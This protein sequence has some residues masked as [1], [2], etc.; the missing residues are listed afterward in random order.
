MTVPAETADTQFF[1]IFTFWGMMYCVYM[2]I[3]LIVTATRDTSTDGQVIGLI[4][5]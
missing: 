2:L 5:V 3:F 4:A 1:I